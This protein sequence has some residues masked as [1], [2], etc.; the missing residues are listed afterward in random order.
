MPANSPLD[1]PQLARAAD[2]L[3]ALGNPTRL[4]L[5]CALAAGE[6]SVQDLCAAV[7][8]GQPMASQHLAVLLG[9]R[10]VKCRKDGNRVFYR[11]A[12]PELLTLIGAVK[13]TFCDDPN[14]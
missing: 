10:L 6:Q 14:A 3:K 2:R 12:D 9:K 1:T 5:I 8:T 4:A 13:T 11:I 7:G